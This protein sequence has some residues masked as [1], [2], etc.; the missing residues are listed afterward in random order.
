VDNAEGDSE[1]C[2]RENTKG[3][4]NLAEICG[5][6]KISYLT[7]SSDLVF[8][9]RKREPYLETDVPNPLNVYGQSKAEAE[10]GILQVNPGTL[11]I[12]T[13]AFFSPWDEYNFLTIALQTLASG[14]Q[15]MAAN[16]N[17]VSPTYLP[18]LV[19]ASLDILI[20]GESGLWHMANQG[21]LTWADFASWAA[22]LSGLKTSLVVGC[23][24][25]DLKLTARRPVYAALGSERGVLLPSL[26]SALHKFLISYEENNKQE[27]RKK[28][29]HA[30]TS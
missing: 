6:N 11:I 21:E 24:A 16:D 4:I 20:D 7:F 3:A 22:E 10:K 9:G 25:A 28:F 17:V 13:A 15:F 8:D 14:K 5:Q 29:K 1:K 26:E 27:A 2:Y 30:A 18:D 23:Q 12:R 19:N